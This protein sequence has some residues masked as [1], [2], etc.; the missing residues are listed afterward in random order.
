MENDKFY[1]VPITTY[2]EHRR[3]ALLQAA[4]T[5]YGDESRSEVEIKICVKTAI[6]LLA[7]IESLENSE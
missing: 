1:K 4:A 2:M 3:F 5:I 6:A 7:E